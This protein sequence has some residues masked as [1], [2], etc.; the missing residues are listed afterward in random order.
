MGQDKEGR[1]QVTDDI[2]REGEEPQE[3]WEGFSSNQSDLDDESLHPARLLKLTKK[4]LPSRFDPSGEA[5]A[6]IWTFGIRD[7]EMYEV[8]GTTSEATGPKSK[9]RPWIESL[10]GKQAAADALKGVLKPDDLIGKDCIVFV[11]IN[12]AGWPKVKQVLPDTSPQSSES[13]NAPRRAAEP[14][15]SG[16]DTAGHSG[17]PEGLPD[18]LDF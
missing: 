12:D 16:P 18:G 1:D 10:M 8:E 3:D 15:I 2:Y 14:V 5:P 17:S 4:R 13:A 6:I 9:A 11:T 7:A